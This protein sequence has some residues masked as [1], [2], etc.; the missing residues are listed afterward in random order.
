M[1][2][3][4]DT[5][6]ALWWITGSEKLSRKG[7][8]FLEEWE[9]ELLVSIASIWEVAIK[10]RLHPDR[11][12]MSEVEYAKYCGATGF[13]VLPIKIRHIFALRTLTRPETAPKHQDPFDRIMIAQVKTERMFFLTHD[14]LLPYYAENCVVYV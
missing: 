5:H 3:L 11:V 6:I 12:S 1:K 7:L 2:L 14:E 10:H 4:L 8:T 13:N 9:N